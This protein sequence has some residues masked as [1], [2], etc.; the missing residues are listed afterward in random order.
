VVAAKIKRAD[1]RRQG[2]DL[3]DEDLAVLE[4]QFPG[5]TARVVSAAATPWQDY[6]ERHAGLAIRVRSAR[7]AAHVEEQDQQAR[8]AAGSQR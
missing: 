1:R 4:R 5:L 7:A 6:S 3:D 2:W 8:E